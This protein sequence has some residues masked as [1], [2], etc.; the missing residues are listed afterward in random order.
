M[1]LRALILTLLIFA[2]CGVLRSPEERAKKRIDK[3]LTKYPDISKQEESRKIDTFVNI[4]TIYTKEVHLDT[5]FFF[6]SD[7]TF[8]VQEGKVITE[9]Q[10][11]NK[12]RVRIKTEVRADT[13]FLT[14]T[15]IREEI[16]IK[17]IIKPIKKTFFHKYGIFI[18]LALLL[19]VIVLVRMF[20]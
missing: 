10:I 4:D 11:Y 3:L 13:I 5:S 17:E 9:V 19:L 8:I 20:L 15:L 18:I 14:D 2:S 6:N 16:R 12:E 1:K 7:T